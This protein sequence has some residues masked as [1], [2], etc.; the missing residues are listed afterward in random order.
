[1][2]TRFKF[3]IIME[4]FLVFG[5]FPFIAVLLNTYLDWPILT[6]I[7][8]TIVGILILGF[9]ILVIV[10]STYDLVIKSKQEFVK[11]TQA[12]PKF[13]IEGIY[14]YVRN[15]MYMGDFLIVLSEFLIFGQI[16]LLGYFF[17]LI[18][19][20]HLAVV[21]QEEP[22]LEAAF[23]SDYLNYKARVPRWFPKF[24]RKN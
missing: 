10:R 16:A 21:Y 13:I 7:P 18:L 23:G 4:L 14:Q 24:I 20:V 1:M 19:L 12:L 6:S 11:P 3:G 15:P 22:T 17:I 5:L 2:S 8:S 9:G